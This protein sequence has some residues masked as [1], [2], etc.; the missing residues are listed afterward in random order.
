[1]LS[2]QRHWVLSAGLFAALGGIGH[3]AVVESR[4][5]AAAGG[6]AQLFVVEYIRMG[7]GGAGRPRL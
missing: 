3:I 6:A 2:M 7:P 4:A 1:M 5:G